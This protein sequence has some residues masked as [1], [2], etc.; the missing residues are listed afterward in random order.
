MTPSKSTIIKNIL[1]ILFILTPVFIYYWCFQKYAVNIPHWDDFAVRNS[2]AKF[3]QTNS[4]SEKIS[5]LFAQHNEHRIFV[6]RLASLIIFS[7]TGTLNV[8]LLMFFGF[9]ALVGIL[10]LFFKILKKYNFPLI[11]FIPIS[12]LIF[13]ISLYEN[14]FWGMASIQNF[15]VIFFG[16]LSFYQLVFSIEN[17]K[18]SLLYFA[19][20]SC[21]LGIFTSSNG[22]LIP[23]I[24]SFI[25]LFQ[26]RKRE[27]FL[28]F[29]S[30]I[31]FLGIFFFNFQKNPDN[32]A[33]TNFSNV[34]ILLKG[35]FAT[36]GNAV[37]FSL[38]VPKKHLDLSMATG[39]LL[40]LF[41]LLFSYQTI[42]KKYNFK[43][44]QNFIVID[45]N[46][47]TNLFL[48]TC[49]TFLGIT[50]VGIVFARSSYGIGT[51]LTSKYKIYSVLIIA[52]LYLITLYS[53]LHK[54]SFRPFIQLSIALSISFNIY[55]YLSDYQNIRHLN[56]ERICDQFKQQYTEKNFPNGGIMTQL[57]EPKT[58]FY[59]SITDEIFQPKENTPL[60]IKVENLTND[61]RLV[62]LKKQ[63]PLDLS[64]P[65]SG[66]YFILKSPKD[67][68]L[69]P[70]K[71][72][73]AGKKAY[74][75]SS[76]LINN[77]LKIDNFTAEF[78]KFYIN[79]GQYLIGEILVENE[80][81]KIT[82][83]KQF[84]DIQ[85]INTEKPK[86]NW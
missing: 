78:S 13:N 57:Q 55:T 63:F 11:S 22:I 79:S 76:F 43:E 72:N 27:F 48:L 65:E 31:I 3:L 35:L 32:V 85:T 2:L 37:D 83:S 1:S 41:M 46:Q 60:N 62:T 34:N 9:L 82:W 29:S 36:L 47:N 12:F 52:I 6:T 20:F 58:T 5:I 86:Q 66:L 50:C 17:T 16:F 30:S 67:T 44:K 68:Y 64:S 33:K 26:Q 69:F 56:Q 21:F 61:F 53:L 42:F 4:F 40:L 70:T 18:K 28:W 38:L 39:F 19:I 14:T 49:L 45:N 74:L 75:N 10:I 25:L 23:I 73:A 51:L 77:Q 8:K 59:E 24:G 54:K 81:K 84:I 15:G 80:T 71:I 7:I